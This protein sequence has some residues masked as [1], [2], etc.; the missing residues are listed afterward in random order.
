[1][2]WNDG[3]LRLNFYDNQMSILDGSGSTGLD[4]AE[5][6]STAEMLGISLR[7]ELNCLPYSVSYG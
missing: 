5:G 6:R 1:V 7:T 3:E 4:G 2:G